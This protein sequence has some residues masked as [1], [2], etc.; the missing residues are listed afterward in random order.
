MY[1][2][3]SVLSE[4]LEEKFESDTTGAEDSQTPCPSFLLLSDRNEEQ[5]SRQDSCSV[6]VEISR[7]PQENAF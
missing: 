2:E 1:Q 3:L 7:N 5:W 6:G 4:S